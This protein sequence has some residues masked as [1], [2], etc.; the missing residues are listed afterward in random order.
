MNIYYSLQSSNFANTDIPDVN[1]TV[2][3][4]QMNYTIFKKSEKLFEYV[5][6]FSIK[7]SKAI[8]QQAKKLI[9]KENTKKMYAPIY[10]DRDKGHNT[11]F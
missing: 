2:M 8:S 7:L 10:P 6:V 1:A 9:Q 11:N 4:N 5:H 3:I